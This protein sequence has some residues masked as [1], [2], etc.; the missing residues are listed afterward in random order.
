MLVK[1]HIWILL[2]TR[3]LYMHNYDIKT[4]NQWQKQ[5]Q[6]CIFYQRKSSFS[7]IPHV[8]LLHI[9]VVTGN[10]WI[11]SALCQESWGLFESLQLCKYDQY[12][13]SIITLWFEIKSPT[14]KTGI[15]LRMELD[16][17]YT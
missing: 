14:Y 7:Y 9:V 11:F 1:F 17:E 10:T 15:Y 3:T 12:F 16:V 6:I 4:S 5:N 2:N 8:L 13:K